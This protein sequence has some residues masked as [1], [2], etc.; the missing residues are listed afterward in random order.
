MLNQRIAEI[1]VAKKPYPNDFAFI[2]T[3]L[4][5]QEKLSSS[6]TVTSIVHGRIIWTPQGT[7][8]ST[9]PIWI[10]RDF[11]INK[12]YGLGIPEAKIDAVSFQSSA[13][14]C[15][16]L[17]GDTPRFSLTYVV[18]TQKSAVDILTEMLTCVRGYM[19]CRDKIC[20]YIDQP[21]TTYYKAIGLDSIIEN[22]FSWW[23][24]AEEDRLN[25]VLIEWVD[26][27]NSYELTTTIFDDVADQNKRGINERSF[28]LRGITN[29]Q[30]AGRMGAL[31]VRWNYWRNKL[32][33]V[34]LGITRRRC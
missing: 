12:R 5:A 23:Q 22:S 6:P 2:A 25:R 29:S 27:A 32:L 20:I 30:Q 14:Y 28:S 4:K 10:I 9:N 31:F 33:F 18:D 1:Q 3:T 13:S 15:D 11:L 8:F 21:V 24:S 26:P 16:E 19:L 17:V 34:Q 7:K